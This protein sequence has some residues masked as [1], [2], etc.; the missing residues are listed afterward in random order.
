MENKILIIDP[1]EHFVELVNRRLSAYGYTNYSSQRTAQEGL[2]QVM[3]EKPDLVIVATKL[4]D[5]DGFDT[6]KH[7]KDWAGDTIKVILLASMAEPN[8]S[9]RAQIAG[10]DEY[11]AKT[12]DCLPLI[13]AIKKL[14]SPMA[15][16]Q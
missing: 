8:N 16:S 11:V 15:V 13:T 2:R 7:I 3:L 14:L 4:A 6:C 10:A 5:A 1:S 9:A 12:L